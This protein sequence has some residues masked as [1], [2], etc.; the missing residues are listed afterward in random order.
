MPAGQEYGMGSAA[1]LTSQV[2]KFFPNLWCV[3]LVGVAAGLPDLSQ[4]HMRDIRLVAYDLGKETEDAFQT[5]RLGHALAT[6][7]PIL[8]SAIMNI[9]LQALEISFRKTYDKERAER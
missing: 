3:L 8:H 6:T 2:E 9:E 4:D 5:L 1:A 7:E